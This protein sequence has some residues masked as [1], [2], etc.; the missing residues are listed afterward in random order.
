MITYIV[1]NPGSGKTYYAVFKIW[2][3]FLFKPKENKLPKFFKTQEIKKPDLL[4]CYTNINQFKFNL[5]EKF[6]KFEYEK[7][8]SDME[9]LHAMYIA[10][11]TDEELNEKA[12]ELK[13]HKVLIVL[14]ECHNFLKAKDDPILVW[15]LTYHRH[16][17]Q[18]I[19]LI[20]Q[21]LTLVNN[22]YKRVAE[23]FLKAIDSSKRLFKNKFRYILYGSYKMFQKDV[24]QKLHVPYLEEVF[25]LYHS[26]Q[27]KSQKSFVRKFLYIALFVFI[28]LVIYFYYFLQFLKPDEEPTKPQQEIT[29]SN[30]PIV[31]K[32]APQP[33]KEEETKPTYIYQFSCINDI[34][35]FQDE[36]ITFP[37]SYISYLIIDSKP[38][39]Y[40]QF[41]KNKHLIEYFMVFDKPLLDDLKNSKK[42]VSDESS[43]TDIIPSGLFK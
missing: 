18:E 42:G 22:E 35:R 31:S 33:I 21:D 8:Y 30:K 4:Y 3:L 12:K 15:W 5:S 20:T 37:Y 6:I 9:I 41:I 29:I 19:V 1:G 34:C 28:A 39:Y 2:Q 13:L 25:N 36:K 26:G 32:P 38:I 10:K 43:K 14:D 27:S 11:A 24:M 23:H 7:F 17:Y 40:T 16:L